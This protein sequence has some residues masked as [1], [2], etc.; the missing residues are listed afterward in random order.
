MKVTFSDPGQYWKPDVK[1]EQYE[2]LSEELI[3]RSELVVYAKTSAIDP[4]CLD[5]WSPWDKETSRLFV[6]VLDM[7]GMDPP[8]TDYDVLII[9]KE[10]GVDVIKAVDDIGV[11]FNAEVYF[12]AGL[13]MSDG[14]SS[15]M[16]AVT[17]IEFVKRLTA[18]DWNYYMDLMHRSDKALKL[19][20][21][22]AER[23]K[24]DRAEE[25]RELRPKW[26]WPLLCLGGAAIL[27]FYF[28][29]DYWYLK[30]L[31]FLLLLP[32]VN[33]VIKYVRYLTHKI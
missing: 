16:D 22:Y 2:S 25:K 13:D 4:K 21:S 24:E 17:K 15:Y 32:M 3:P 19:Y 10:D 6:V 29:M 8:V 18:T 14:S 1:P 23:E 7:C 9:K 12:S 26:I 5:W 28:N 33:A 30:A 27:F 20:H 11:T 31:A